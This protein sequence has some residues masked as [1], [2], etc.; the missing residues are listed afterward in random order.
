MR[1]HQTLGETNARRADWMKTGDRS[2][3]SRVVDHAESR[4]HERLGEVG[5][6]HGTA[7]RLPITANARATIGRRTSATF[8]ISASGS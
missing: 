5:A 3:H 2:R 6:L 8:T 4:G 7:K 1:C